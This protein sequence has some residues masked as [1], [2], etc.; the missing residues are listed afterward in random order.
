MTRLRLRFWTRI[1][2]AAAKLADWALVRR[3]RRAVAR[4]ADG[5]TSLL[6]WT[7]ET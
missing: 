5:F 3:A 4:T 6:R 7:P 2:W 1:A